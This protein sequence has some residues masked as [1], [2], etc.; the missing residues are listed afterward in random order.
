[1]EMMR[2]TAFAAALLCIPMSGLSGA[3][4]TTAGMGRFA[5][6]LYQQFARGQDNVALSPLC[7]IS[8]LS[9]LLDGARGQTAAQLAKALHQAY[10]DSSHYLTVTGLLN[11]I[12]RHGNAEGS[13]LTLANGVFTQRGF[14]VRPD[15][16]RILVQYYH[17]S[18]TQFD[19]AGNPEQA[20]I[21]IN[22]WT[23]NQTKG[24]LQDLFAPGTLSKDTRLVLTSAVYFHGLWQ[25]EFHD[26]DTHPA[27]FHA[28]ARET[29]SVPMMSLT[30]PLGYGEAPGLQILE[31]RYG[32]SP[33]VFDVLLPRTAD[34]L[35]A[36]ETSL[37]PEKLAAYWNGLGSRPVSVLLPRFRVDTDV[38]LREAL[39]HMGVSDAFGGKADFS[40]I[41]DRNDLVLSDVR[42]K[43]FVEVSE[44]GTIAAALS[45][46]AVSLTSA[47]PPPVTFRADHPFLFLIRDPHT[48]IIVFMGRLMKPKG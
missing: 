33:L 37:T 42:H 38:S 44:Q 24:K 10:P 7:N 41:A 34:G 43:A 14:A 32:G 27:P 45:G 40:P 1:M 12:T 46:S 29:V 15:Y 18:A 20:R 2:A 4:T 3:D 5:C 13:E 25:T 22:F 9:M 26:T 39:V 19:F 11:Q 6:E 16:E 47:G 31:M 35:N 28:G 17:A 8:A 30:A 21:G 48:G 36:L 23:A